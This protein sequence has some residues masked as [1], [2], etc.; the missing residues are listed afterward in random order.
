MTGVIVVVVVVEVVIL[1]KNIID[2]GVIPP[3]TSFFDTPLSDFAS[4]CFFLSFYLVNGC[5][6]K[7]GCLL[8]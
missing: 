5:A 7:T 6:A 8:L 2:G 1:Y 4:L 3:C